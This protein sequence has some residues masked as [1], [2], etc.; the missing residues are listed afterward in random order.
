M[1]TSNN[2]AKRL[3]ELRNSN[4][5]SQYQLS[6]NLNSVAIEISRA[7]IANY[8]IGK[9]EPNFDILIKLATFFNVSTDYLLGFSDIKRPCVLTEMEHVYLDQT[10]NELLLNEAMLNCE[11]MECGERIRELRKEVKLSVDE[12][13]K[14][15]DFVPTFYVEYENNI[16]V[17]DVLT[18]KKMS[19]IFNCPPKYILG[20]TDRRYFINFEDRLAFNYNSAIDRICKL[21][22]NNRDKLFDFVRLL[23]LSEKE[24]TNKNI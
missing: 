21:S 23:E 12:I 8:E 5:L 14:I 4:N 24:E 9:R 15:L 17:P 20:F 3:V 1:K 19:V 6:K 18:L 10:T 22:S 11:P 16:R 2:F 13:S 7:Q